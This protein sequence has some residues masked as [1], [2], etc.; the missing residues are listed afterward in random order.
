MT[1]T[2]QAAQHE[3]SEAIKAIFSLADGAK[4]ETN[5][6]GSQ[7]HRLFGNVTAPGD[8]F[9]NAAII[10]W[11][12]ACTQADHVAYL[13][14]QASAAEATAQDDE[15]RAADRRQWATVAAA[16]QSD[17]SAGHNEL[18]IS[19]QQ[20]AELYHSIARS[21]TAEAAA[22]YDVEVSIPLATALHYLYQWDNA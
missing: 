22:H 20:S 16:M 4:R 13:A 14:Q 9:R 12:Y 11:R 19:Y 5:A 2:A 1:S 15:R 10:L 3:P 21:F 6:A 7:I 17:L 8:H 18:A